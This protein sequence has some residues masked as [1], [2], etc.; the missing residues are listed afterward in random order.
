MS[1]MLIRKKFGSQGFASRKR[2]LQLPGSGGT[3][4]AGSV[5]RIAHLAFLE[6]A[7]F[8][9]S[10]RIQHFTEYELD[11]PAVITKLETLLANLRISAALCCPPPDGTH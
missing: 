8:V 6:Q 5:G 10:H 1:A 9:R 11:G 3:P 4:G 7:G 2:P